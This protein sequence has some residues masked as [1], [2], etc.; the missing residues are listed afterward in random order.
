MKKTVKE[1]EEGMNKS[2]ILAG[3]LTPHSQQLTEQVAGK[4][5]RI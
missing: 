5:V 1:L 3:D 4:S 2:I